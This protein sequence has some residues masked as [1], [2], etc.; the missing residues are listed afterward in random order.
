MA[1]EDHGG[2]VPHFPTLVQNTAAVGGMTTLLALPQTLV[3]PAQYRVFT[4]L[5]LAAE[6]MLTPPYQPDSKY[7]KVV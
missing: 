3:H 4:L 1:S 5:V 7:W 2:E 6:R